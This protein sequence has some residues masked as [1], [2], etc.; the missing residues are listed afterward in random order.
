MFATL[1]HFA[2]DSLTALAL[3]SPIEATA[4]ILALAL[5]AGGLYVTRTL[6]DASVT[7]AVNHLP[8]GPVYKKAA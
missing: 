4:T 7:V 5:A 8:D 2:A 3:L 6:H 1:S